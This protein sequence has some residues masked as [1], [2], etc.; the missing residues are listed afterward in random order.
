VTIAKCTKKVR[1][2]SKYGTHC[3]V[4]FWKM[5]K[6]TE[7]SQHARMRLLLLWQNQDEETTGC[8]NVTLWFL[9]ENSGWWCLDLHHPS[10]VTVKSAIR[11]LK[12]LIDQ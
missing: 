12:E 2:V 3:G 5:V 1:I 6:K 9:H 7:M 8:G 11:R 4:S 10:V